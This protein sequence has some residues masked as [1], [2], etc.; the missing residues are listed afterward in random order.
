MPTQTA[1]PYNISPY[2]TDV[3]P[4]EYVCT[5]NQF[6]RGVGVGVVGVVGVLYTCPGHWLPLLFAGAVLSRLV[7]SGR[8]SSAGWETGG[9]NRSFSQVGRCNVAH[10]Q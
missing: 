6:A 2:S 4:I 7:R 3:H 10:D 5:G 1:S 8:E 9:E